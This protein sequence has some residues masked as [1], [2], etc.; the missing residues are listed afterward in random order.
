MLA[1][2]FASAIISLL[3]LAAYSYVT[4]Q[5]SSDSAHLVL[6]SEEA[7]SQLSLL[8][9]E[10]S[11]AEPPTRS[12]TA[13]DSAAS[14]DS[15]RAGLALFGRITAEDS[16]TQRALGELQRLILAP[17]T[18]QP[19]GA[20][21]RRTEIRRRLVALSDEQ[22]SVL[23]A[24]TIGAEH[25]VDTATDVRRIVFAASLALLVSAFWVLARALARK[26]LEEQRERFFQVSL[27]MLVFAGFDGYFKRLNPAWERTL[28]F[29]IEELLARPQIEFVHPDDR[30]A[31]LRQAAAVR[32][33]GTA[34]SFENRYRCK[35][36]SYKWLLWN[37]VPS[38][39]HQTIYAVARDLTE[40]KNVEVQ[41]REL[42]LRDDLTSLRNR[43]GFLLLAE[44]ELKLVRDRR[45]ETPDIHLWLIFADV[46]GLKSINDQLGHDVG[47]QALVQAAEILTKTFRDA[48]VIAR[49][50]GDEFAILALTNEADGGE[51]MVARVQEVLRQYNIEERLPYRLSL[52]L[53]VVKVDAT[54]VT[55]IEEM[56][57]EADRQM[58]EHKRSD[59]RDTP[60]PA[61]RSVRE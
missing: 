27:D 39:E 24:R 53:G 19:A 31:T 33:G 16:L 20:E 10:I 12:R 57:K 46:D 4:A 40:R 54:R 34:V 7:L 28:G 32:A 11:D 17:G 30:E 58:Y 41:L 61:V 5:R 43:R 8:R 29:T 25:D 2:A 59:R 44:Q 48:D 37:S 35:D 38:P 60:V 52:S 22:R 6:R 26:Q 1:L 9:A 21:L 51:K 36:G 42:S 23:A 47:S 49:I 45:R 15:I 14:M 18:G 55:S 13:T 3:A 50:G 56:L